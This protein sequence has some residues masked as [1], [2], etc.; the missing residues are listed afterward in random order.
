M[1]KVAVD[2]DKEEWISNVVSEE[3]KAKKDQGGLNRQW[4]GWSEA[5]IKFNETH[6]IDTVEVS[7]NE[8]TQ[9]L[10]IEGWHS[11]KAVREDGGFKINEN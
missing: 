1:V 3:Y 10:K 4:E 6:D 9:K 5:L 7:Y 2:G 8:S 11:I